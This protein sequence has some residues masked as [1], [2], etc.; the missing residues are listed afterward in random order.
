MIENMKD[1]NGKMQLSK[2]TILMIMERIMKRDALLQPY[3][4]DES[5]KVVDR[6]EEDYISF[7]TGVSGEIRKFVL[8][9]IRTL[10]GVCLQGRTPNTRSLKK[11]VW[12]CHC[13]P[14]GCGNLVF[15]REF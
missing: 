14:E 15:V 11:S 12:R 4:E 6:P 13:E 3:F 7:K 10:R 9:R 2:K 5:I 1:R 8:E